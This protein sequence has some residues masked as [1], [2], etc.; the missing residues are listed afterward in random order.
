[1][2]HVATVQRQTLIG[3]FLRYYCR[4]AA[5]IIICHGGDTEKETDEDFLRV[6]V[7][8]ARGTY[9]GRERANERGNIFASR[10]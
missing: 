2:I 8:E 4:T 7:R 1:M 9:T 5:T 10:E 6:P 3:I